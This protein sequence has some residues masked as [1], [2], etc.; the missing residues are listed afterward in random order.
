MTGQTWWRLAFGVLA[1]VLVATV[2]SWVQ[3]QAGKPNIL[4]RKSVV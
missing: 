1:A 3:A 2:P 4:D